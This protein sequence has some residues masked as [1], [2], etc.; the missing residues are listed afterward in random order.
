MYFAFAVV[1]ELK[2]REGVGQGEMRVAEL[3]GDSS[4][5]MSQ[6]WPNCTSESTW[7]CHTEQ[8]CWATWHWFPALG[9][10]QAPRALPSMCHWTAGKRLRAALLAKSIHS[11]NHVQIQ[12]KFLSRSD[13]AGHWQGLKM[14]FLPSEA[15]AQARNHRISSSSEQLDFLPA[16]PPGHTLQKGFAEQTGNEVL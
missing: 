7:P 14:Q 6:G 13:T 4:V 16:L 8:S 11:G 2:G 1:L 3:T 9:P 10:Q 5:L 12:Q 15:P